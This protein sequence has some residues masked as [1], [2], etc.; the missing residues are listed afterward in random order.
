MVC[1]NHGRIWSM[2]S[3]LIVAPVKIHCQLVKVYGVCVI[4]WKQAALVHGFQLWQDRHWRVD[5]TTDNAWCTDTFSCW[6]CQRAIHS[7]GS[8]QN[9]PG[10]TGLHRSACALGAEESRRWWQSSLYGTV[11]AFLVSIGHV[12]LIIESS[13]GTEIWLMTQN[14]KPEKGLWETIIF[15]QQRKWKNRC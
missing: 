14:L 9:C 10:P 3:V 8:A 1:Q 6:H 15:L 2:K 7:V 11:W 5:S 12:T 13:F 4:P